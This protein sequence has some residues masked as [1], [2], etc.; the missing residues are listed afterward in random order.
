MA[1]PGRAGLRPILRHLIVAPW[2]RRSA[3]CDLHRS[4]RDGAVFVPSGPGAPSFVAMQTRDASDLFGK[5][6]DRHQRTSTGNHREP[7][8]LDC[9]R[10]AM[11]RSVFAR[12]N[13]SCCCMARE[14]LP[15]AAS[16]S[17][18]CAW[19]YRSRWRLDQ[20][21]G[22]GPNCRR[23]PRKDRTQPAGTPRLVD[24]RLRPQDSRTD[25]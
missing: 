13:I 11:A 8:A 3:R 10:R 18:S 7:S 16:V 14:M 9:A 19:A 1:A 22:T 2:G 23:T 12:L 21:R 15:P 24:P 5:R 4:S 17:S 20:Q 6:D 25:L